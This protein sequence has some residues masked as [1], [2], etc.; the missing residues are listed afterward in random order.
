MLMSC[1]YYLKSPDYFWG[2]V[3][4]MTTN[5]DKEDKE[6]DTPSFTFNRYMSRRWFVAI[7]LALRFM[8]S[9]PPIFWDKFWEV[10]N[11]TAAF[12]EHIKNIFLASC[13]ICLDE[14]MSIWH[15]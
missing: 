8:S 2:A 10:R 14:S 15:N 1:Y 5:N 11:M 4:R 12:N 9:N 13:V 3:P 7:T 6:N